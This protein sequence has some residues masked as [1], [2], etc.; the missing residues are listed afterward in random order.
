MKN[1]SGS[2]FVEGTLDGTLK[3]QPIKGNIDQFGPCQNKDFCSVK[4]LVQRSER[5]VTD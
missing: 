1:S 2:M 3:R 5:L 4:D